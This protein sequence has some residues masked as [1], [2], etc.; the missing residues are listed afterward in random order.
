MRFF[1]LSDLHLKKP[2]GEYKNKTSNLLKKLCSKIRQSTCIGEAVLFVILGD[3]ADRGS[4]L[5]FTTA[6]ESL[7]LICDE[8]KDYHVEFEFVPG[9]HDLHDGTLTLF[10]RLILKYGSSALY[11]NIT[12]YSRIHDGVNF[13]FADSTLSRD[14]AA[15]GKLDLEAIRANIKPGLTNILFCHH[16]ISHGHGDPH[17][18]IEDGASVAAQLN[19]IGISFLFHGHV[20]DARITIPDQG[21]IE[22][23]CGSLSGG[24][25]WLPAVFHQ[26]LVGY[27]QAGRVVCIERWIDTEDG[28][29]DFALSELYPTPKNFRDPDTVGKN[30]YAPVLPYIP[31]KVCTYEDYYKGPFFGVLPQEKNVSLQYA[32]QMRAKVL[33]LCEAGMGKSTELKN[34]AFE[35]CN[36]FHTFLYSLEGYNGEDIDDLLPNTYRQLPPNRIALL[37]D[38]YDELDTRLAKIFRI[39]LKQYVQDAMGVHVVIS[40]RSNFCGNENEN[41][42]K[43]FDGF[44]VYVLQK[45][46]TEQVRGYLESK[47]IDTNQFWRCANARGVNELIYNPFYLLRLA[48]VY[49]KEK[50]LP[51]K[52]SLMEKLIS[53]TFSADFLKFSDDLDERYR[54]LIASLEKLAI[55]MQLMHQQSFDDREAYQAVL[56]SDER[57]LAKKS[58]LLER[59]GQRWKFLHN[60]FREYFAARFLSRLPQNI[61]IPVFYDGNNV[62]PYWVNTLGYYAGFTLDWNF[63]DWLKE[64]SPTAL[65]KFESDRLAPG[66]RVAV[67]KSVFEKYEA[68]DLYFHDD[69]C[70]VSELARFVNSNEVLSFLLDRIQSPRNRMS[71]HNAINILRYYPS[72]FDKRNAVRET[73][74]QCCEKYPITDKSVCRLAIMALCQLGLQTEETTSRL[75]SKFGDVN[76]DYI[77]LGMYEYFLETQLWDSYVDYCLSGIDLVAHDFD[78]PNETRI[79]NEYSALFNCLTRM[80]T[81]KSVRHLLKW[82]SRRKHSEFSH[83]D[84]VLEKAVQSAISLYNSGQTE[85]Y[86]LC[87]SLF[88][89]AVKDHNIPVS[90]AMIQFFIKTGTQ[91][92]VA[93]TAT[94]NYEDNPNLLH[95]LIRAD[96]SIIEHLKIKYVE[97]K[98]KPHKVFHEIVKWGVRNALKYKEYAELVKRI[99]A[100]DLPKY[101]APIDYEALGQKAKRE[102]FE[103]LFDS[104]KLKQLTEQ[105]L[106]TIGDKD[107]TTRQL[108]ESKFKTDYP[109]A[110]YLLK[111]AMYQYGPDLKVSEFFNR[112]NLDQFVLWSAS[113]L[114]S[115]KSEVVPNNEE[116]EKLSRIVSSTLKTRNFKNSVQYTLTDSSVKVQTV[117]LLFMIQYL[118][119]PLDE[120]TLLDLTELPHFAFD[121]NNEQTKY[122]YLARKLSLDKL[123][124]R[125]V[126]NVEMGTV[127]ASVLKDHLEFLDHCRDSSLAEYARNMCDGK[128]DADLRTSAWRYLYD[129]LGAEYIADEILPI[130]DE[131]LLLEISDN[132]KDIPIGKLCAALERKY[133]QHPSIQLQAHLITY[134]S[135]KAIT[136]YVEKVA[137]EKHPPEGKGVHVGGPTEAISCISNPV[138]LPQLETLLV[139]V[140]D[141]DF[142]DC[143]WNELQNSLTKAFAHCGTE[144]YEETLELIQRHRPPADKD[145]K[146]Y[147]YCNSIIQEV[148]RARKSMGD[149]AMSLVQTKAFLD[150]AKKYCCLTC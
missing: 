42:S 139:V 35:L 74:L 10:D 43:N 102:Y 68:L 80:S 28:Y 24:I 134:G 45:I 27:L 149:K 116:K 11:E 39:K 108:W 30:A 150:E 146:N 65:V 4:E 143:F 125:L 100:T 104:E 118:D 99:D 50:D 132:C 127:K 38:G 76:E 36:T 78:N 33:L 119:Y 131:S 89:E 84:D 98:L 8:L 22:V 82:F 95:I 129:T 121:K 88:S 136:D 103:S 58:G 145:E 17:D 93:M 122:G 70:D 15:P 16:A 61:V 62:K 26:F 14:Y 64:K 117:N 7:D 148:E 60:N 48:K 107:V 32:M 9:N 81:V 12:A 19:S 71:Q 67:F 41:K 72:L 130:A 29:K 49:A 77:R 21:L 109:S 96:D 63:S 1:V 135:R 90:K 79:G 141:P 51:L 75:M 126:Q 40:S 69:L 59:E 137:E 144:A 133:S 66:V 3:I 83:F 142:K 97:G 106:N 123:K 46:S 113:R 86:E 57:D 87:V 110:L 31:R 112:V 105:L 37:L 111:I 34:L 115:G 91:Y 6:S 2:V 114:L 13:I 56:S 73:L 120:E 128:Y 52:N 18:V 53:D 138:F 54:E 5:S 124:R 94:E 101:E 92:S 140:L 25:E 20:H 85:L 147:R 55:S 47:N 44:Y 23:G